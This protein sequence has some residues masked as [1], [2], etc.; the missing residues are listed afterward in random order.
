[1]TRCELRN[2]Q[3]VC[4]GP[5]QVRELAWQIYTAIVTQP[6]YNGHSW[7]ASNQAIWEAEQFAKRWNEQL[8]NGELKF[9]RET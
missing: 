1:M 5:P 4:M 8:A 3:Q 9:R 7:G 6:R 2:E